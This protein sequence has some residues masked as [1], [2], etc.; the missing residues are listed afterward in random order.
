MSEWVD[1]ATILNAS[2]SKGELVVRCT[3]GSSFL[4]ASGQRASFVPPVLDAPR[5]A[6]VEHTSHIDG[7]RGAVR[8]TGVSAQDAA[9]LVGCHVLVLRSELDPA[10]L[11]AAGGLGGYEV[12]DAL[13]G[14]VGTVAGLIDNPAQTLLEVERP[15]G[16][17]VLVPV[18]DEIVLDVDD[19]VRRVDIAAPAGLFDL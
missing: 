6:A 1:V 5:R 17:M 13:T 10:A 4:L 19:Q 12:H 7:M 8:F 3:A 15:D 2:G 9:K 14:Y 11:D 18:V 16:S